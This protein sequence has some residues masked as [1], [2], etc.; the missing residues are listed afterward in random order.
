MPAA[1]LPPSHAVLLCLHALYPFLTSH[2]DAL[3][4]TS[5]SSWCARVHVLRITR[6]MQV[7]CDYYAQLHDECADC[8]DCQVDREGNVVKRYG[9]STTPLQI[10][11]DIQ[12]LL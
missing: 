3:R 6:A 1:V 2:C 9:S 10:E 11:G 12:K 8:R 5:Q 4:R 7:Q